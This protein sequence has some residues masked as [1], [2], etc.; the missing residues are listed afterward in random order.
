MNCGA[1]SP[2]SPYILTIAASARG[3]SAVSQ[4]EPI[5]NH[6]LCQAASATSCVAVSLSILA[7]SVRHVARQIA[8]DIVGIDHALVLAGRDVRLAGRLESDV[9]SSG[10]LLAGVAPDLV[11]L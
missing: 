11:I 7:M 4:H 3:R 8:G 6:S 10:V 9:A 2:M 1:G 5:A